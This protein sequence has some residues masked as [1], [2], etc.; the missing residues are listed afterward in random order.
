[1]ALAP[2]NQEPAQDAGKREKENRKSGDLKQKRI[3]RWN[4][5]LSACDYSLKHVYGG[6]AEYWGDCH[7][8]NGRDRHDQRPFPFV[9]AGLMSSSPQAYQ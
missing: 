3:P 7:G 6:N 4:K 5:W 2:V 9:G 8:Q 1:M